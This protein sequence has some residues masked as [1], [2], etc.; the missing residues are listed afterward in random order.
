M[1]REAMEVAGTISVTHAVRLE[2]EDGQFISVCPELGTMSCGDT[3]EEALS[4]LNEAVVVYL[5]ALEEVGEQER[6]FR[7][8][9][10]AILPDPI[11]EEGLYQVQGEAQYRVPA[12]A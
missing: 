7:E 8:N 5:N 10:I 1:G 12:L 4:N 9:G 2:K 6:V 3:I 11:E